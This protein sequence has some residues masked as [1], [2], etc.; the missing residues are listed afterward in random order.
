MQFESRWNQEVAKEKDQQLNRQVSPSEEQQGIPNN[1]TCPTKWN[2]WLILTLVTPLSV[3]RWKQ[4]AESGHWQKSRMQ[5]SLGGRVSSLRHYITVRESLW[6]DGPQACSHIHL[7]LPV[8]TDSVWH[9]QLWIKRQASKVNNWK[10]DIFFPV[11][12]AKHIMVDVFPVSH[13]ITKPQLFHFHNTPPQ[14]HFEFCY[15]FIHHPWP[16]ER[17]ILYIWWHYILCFQGDFSLCALSLS[18]TIV[19]AKWVSNS[20]FSIQRRHHH[21]SDWT[22]C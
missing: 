16:A 20:Y 4:Q 7:L 10:L 6:T 15:A 11:R 18:Q 17:E 12:G 13:S 3:M 1:T 19:V 9:V 2:K 22:T 21:F 8:Y 14:R 5:I